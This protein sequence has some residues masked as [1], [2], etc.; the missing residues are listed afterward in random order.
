MRISPR[1]G[2][3]PIEGDIRP[4]TMANYQA[5]SRCYVLRYPIGGLRL[6]SLSELDFKGHYAV[7]RR[8]GGRAR[9]G[10]SPTTVL[11][12]HVMLRRALEDAVASRLIPRNPAPRKRPRVERVEHAWLLP[13]QVGEL[14]AFARFRDP[15]LYPA[16]RLAALD[17]TPAGRACGPPLVGYRPHR[18]ND[19]HLSNKDHRRGRGN[20]A[21]NDGGGISSGGSATITSSVFS[22]NTSEHGGAI[23]GDGAL[24]VALSTFSNNTASGYVAA[25]GGINNNGGIFTVT[26]STFTGNTASGGDA[27]GGTIYG[28]GF[29]P[30]LEVVGSTLSGN[31]A[32]A[33]DGARGGA[34]MSGSYNDDGI[35]TVTNSTFSGNSAMGGT[36]PVSGG[37]IDSMSGTITNSTL[38]GNSISP[39]P[40]SHG[41]GIAST[42][43]IRRRFETLSWRTAWWGRLLQLDRRCGTQ[44]LL[45]RDLRIRRQQLA[46]E[47]RP[48]PRT[49]RQQRWPDRDDASGGGLSGD[50]PNSLGDQ[51]VRD[52]DRDR[53]AGSLPAPG[54]QPRHRCRG[55]GGRVLHVQWLLRSGGQRRRQRGLSYRQ[56]A[57]RLEA[58]GLRPRSGGRWHP[59]MVSRLVNNKANG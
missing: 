54:H 21:S 33:T 2:F 13:E 24:N 23:A 50:R 16:F 28:T 29:T 46:T 55:G 25:G 17:E 35:F 15:D 42:F 34:I 49:A 58:E 59:P 10:L 19:L 36:A 22:D 32:S 6:A 14:L 20:T 41:G 3:R 38:W 40:N 56:I 18:P 1:T 45:G 5:L 7:L 27:Y 12:V 26:N 52:D 30:V 8:A 39:G 53:P 37:A 48:Q 4:T 51:R 11:H 43:P 31:L 44:H 57:D 47:H 9:I